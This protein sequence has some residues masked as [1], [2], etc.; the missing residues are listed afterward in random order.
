MDTATVR[1]KSPSVT[2]LLHLLTRRRGTRLPPWTA[3][4]HL[5]KR[6]WTGGPMCPSLTSRG[7]SSTLVR[8]TVLPRWTVLSPVAIH[9]LTRAPMPPGLTVKDE[10]L[11]GGPGRHHLE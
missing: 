1:P 2:L 7:Q 4:P 10:G 5:L 9:T 6:T 3:L 8:G 11:D